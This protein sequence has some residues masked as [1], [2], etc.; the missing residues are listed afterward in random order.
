MLGGLTGG[1][2]SS[3]ASD[4]RLSARPK[5]KTVNGSPEVGLSRMEISE[6]RD[7]Q[8][9]VPDSYSPDKPAPLALSLHGGGGGADKSISR[10]QGWAAE[11]GIIL[12]GAASQD[13]TWDVI[14]GDFGDDVARIDT[15][16]K[17]VFK[18]YAVD[19]E[20]VAVVGFS[21]GASYS[22]SLGFTNGDL[23][24]HVMAF[25]PGFSVPAERRG[26]P[27]V[28]ISH[29]TEDPVLPIDDTSRQI[30]PELEGQ[31]YDVRFVEFDGG[32]R[33]YRPA[34]DESLSWF[35]GGPGG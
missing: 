24:T 2:G 4:G 25:S 9:F 17:Q 20:K 26:R 32:H 31:G 15:A 33:V 11:A 28:F 7:F 13:R 35:L 27:S 3:S 5:P 30:V 16:L 14:Y 21:D 12:V 10:F 1:S 29:G 23:F 34:R 18:N 19:P 22:L 6:E 8:L